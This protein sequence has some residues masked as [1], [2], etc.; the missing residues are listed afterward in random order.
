MGE[1]A[2]SNSC[3]VFY[4]LDEEKLRKRMSKTNGMIIYGPTP[5]IDLQGKIS[6]EYYQYLKTA[7]LVLTIAKEINDNG[8]FYPVLGMGPGL[9]DIVQF[10]CKQIVPTRLKNKNV[11]IKTNIL[12]NYQISRFFYHL[13]DYLK[14]A[15]ENRNILHFNDN[16]GY[17]I[18]N[19]EDKCM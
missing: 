18:E 12:E 1:S 15:I 17:E 19:A 10:S 14:E 2:F 16:Y 4:D 9:D 11:T 3:P 6:E 8:D 5:N 13:P 7:E